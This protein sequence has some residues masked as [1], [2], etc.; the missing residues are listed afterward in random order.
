MPQVYF[1]CFVGSFIGIY[2]QMEFSRKH[3]DPFDMIGVLMGDHNGGEVPGVNADNLKPTDQFL[4][5]KTVIDQDLG[6]TGDDQ[7]AVPLTA[8]AEN[9]EFHG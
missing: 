4:A 9:G 3:S 7:G 6:S 1:S 8:A 5:G 2:R